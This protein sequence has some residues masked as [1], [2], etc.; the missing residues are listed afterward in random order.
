M[1]KEEPVLAA[2]HASTWSGNPPTSKR[3]SYRAVAKLLNESRL[4][5]IEPPSMFFSR[6][7]SRIFYCCLILAP[8]LFSGC[9]RSY[10]PATE[11]VGGTYSHPQ[12][13]EN[14][15]LCHESK[16]PTVL[17]GTTTQFLH[18][19]APTVDCSSCHHQPGVVWSD[20][21]YSHS[22]VP[23]ACADC[24]LNDRPG[25]ISG[26]NTPQGQFKHG[27]G[28]H[29]Q[30]DCTQCHHHP[31]DRWLIQNSELTSAF[32]GRCHD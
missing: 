9:L 18:S 28:H 17:V 24:H 13:T 6:Q 3:P 31:G 22:P 12:F 8:L 23:S 15:S 30:Y 2:I 14:C 27:Q 11:A 32:C 4:Y 29:S 21:Y 26:F 20:G 1:K 7:I 5:D 10:T 19:S 25:L 16:R